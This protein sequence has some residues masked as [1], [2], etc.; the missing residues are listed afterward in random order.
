MT[1]RQTLRVVSLS[2]GKDS[3]A[4][5]LVALEVHGLGSVRAVFA[6]TGNEHETTYEYAL[7]YLPRA[8]GITVDVVRA[9]FADEF[10]TKRANLAR[11]A[12]GEPESAVYG[13]REFMYAWTPEAAARALELLHPTGNPFLDLCM[14]RGGFPSRKRQF[15][16]EYLK[17]NPLT[18]YQLGLIDSGYAV[19]SWQGVRADE[20]EARRWLPSYES[21]GGHYSVFRPILRWKVGDV[22]DAHA[23][24]GIRANPLYRAGMSRVGCM[25]CINAGKLE[26]R[27]IAK[28]FPEHV[29]RIAEWERLVSEVCRPES[30]VSFFHQGTTGHSGQASTIWQVVEWS[31]TTRGGRQ[32][33]LLADAEPAT[34]CASAYGLC[35]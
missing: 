31:K 23:A 27:E 20:S 5:L 13:R 29:E 35:E 4:T 1:D 6:D 3:T 9:D 32:Y 18:E 10:A 15:C 17:R 21:R 22:F 11:I 12:A 19:E 8:L 25:P 24:A 14:V 33:D 30:P 28:R 16:T 2:G 34:A 26:L 7:E